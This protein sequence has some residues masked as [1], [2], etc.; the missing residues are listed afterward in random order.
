VVRFSS[1]ALV[2]AAQERGSEDNITC[3]VA[4]L[5]LPAAVD[6]AGAGASAS[7]GAGAGAAAGGRCAAS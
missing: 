3:M 1:L 7:A 2:R 5:P 6:A 4:Q